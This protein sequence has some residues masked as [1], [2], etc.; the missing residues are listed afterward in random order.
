LLKLK[1]RRFLW[2]KI[3]MEKGPAVFEEGRGNETW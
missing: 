2:K 3:F 1:E